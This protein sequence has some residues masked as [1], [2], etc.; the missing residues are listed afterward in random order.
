MTGM[1]ATALGLVVG[2]ILLVSVS[3]WAPAFA[4]S[5]ATSQSN[6]ADSA[7]AAL[8]T[9]LRA[10]RAEVAEATQRSVR[11]QL[12]L[13]RLQ[14]QEQRLVYLD[15]QRSDAATRALEAS[16][17]TAG[18]AAQVEQLDRGCGGAATAEQRRDCEQAGT[19][20]KRQLDTQ[21]AFEQQLRTQESDLANALTQE[22]ARWSD[23]NSRL[24]D[25]ERSLS[26]R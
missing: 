13:G 16:R 24:D 9:E 4:Q 21:L 3:S 15:R 11:T 6:A 1:R 8:V 23:V 22:Q 18:L 10:L 2:A 14:M 26:A 25:L 20:F 17:A 19:Q 12:L 5:P 7:L